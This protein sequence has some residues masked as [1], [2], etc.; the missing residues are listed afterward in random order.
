M[1]TQRFNSSYTGSRPDI[2]NLVPKWCRN[3]LDIGASTGELGFQIKSKTGAKVTGVEI[4]PAMAKEAEKKLDLV[5]VGNIEDEVTFNKLKGKK[6]D[7]IILA[8]VLEHLV[9]PEKTLSKLTSLLSQDGVVAISI[10]N[11]RHFQ[12]FN[13]LFLRGDWPSNDRG[14]FDKTHLHQFTKKNIVSLLSKA[15]LKVESLGANYRVLETNH[16][17]NKYAKFF[18]FPGISEFFAYQYLLLARKIK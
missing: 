2:Q 4:S 14:L 1:K 12:T 9:N 6:F 16:H 8:D 17:L 11:I 7:A 5:V 3:I 15:N 18:A 10:P 13:N